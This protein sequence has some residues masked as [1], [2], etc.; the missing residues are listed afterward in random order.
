MLAEAHMAWGHDLKNIFLTEENEFS[1]H[2]N[3]ITDT[4]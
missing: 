4:V 1:F 3:T 2:R